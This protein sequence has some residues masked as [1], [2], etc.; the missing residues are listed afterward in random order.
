MKKYLFIA[1][2][3]FKEQFQ[4]IGNLTGGF[5]VYGI[6]VFVFLQLWLYIYGNKAE[7]FGYSLNQLIWY[8]IVT[9]IVLFT[10]RTSVVT[11][12]IASDVKSGKIAY[13]LNKPYKYIMY[14]M[15]KHYGTMLVFFISYVVLGIAIGATFVG[16]L[17]TFNFVSI[18]F[19]ILTLFCS[20]V[21]MALMYILIGLSSFWVEENAPFRWLLS[22]LLVVLGVTF[23][24]EFMP[25]W[26]K[27]FAKT[28]PVYPVT[29]GPAKMLVDFSIVE[30]VDVFM[31]QILYIVV[32]SIFVTLVY[33]KG[34]RRLNVNGG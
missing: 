30:F 1:K 7:L 9:E 31:M 23:P 4:Y 16:A 22:K 27:G 14:I 5:F 33:I 29:Y 13:I 21:I 17:E 25:D 20:S 26:I 32:L 2:S 12:E 8:V 11:S 10:F 19:L 3:A 24:I 34:V 18:P 28:S 15:S 6:I